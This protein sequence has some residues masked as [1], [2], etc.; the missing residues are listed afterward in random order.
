MERVISL[1][2]F[3]ARQAR[4]RGLAVVPGIAKTKRKIMFDFFAAFLLD[5]KLHRE[6]PSR[7]VLHTYIKGTIS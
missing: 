7:V 4:Y 2:T 3:Q 6:V 1:N 5:I